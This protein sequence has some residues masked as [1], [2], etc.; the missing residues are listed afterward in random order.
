VT[1]RK[2]LGDGMEGVQEFMQRYPY[3]CLEQLASQVIALQDEARWNALMKKLPSYLDK[4]G[5]AK[6]FPMMLEGDDTLTS[7]LLSVAHEAGYVIPEELRNKM[8]D[9]LSG[10]IE[11][12]V[13]RYSALPTSD[14]SGAQAGGD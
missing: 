10:F 11:G 8:R 12:R 5:L 9:G 7:Y 14:L 4:A 6:Y 2:R 1:F 13:I 3:T